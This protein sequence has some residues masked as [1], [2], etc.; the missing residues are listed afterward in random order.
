MG[1]SLRT[2]EGGLVYHALNPGNARLV[3]FDDD[4]D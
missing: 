3:V 1:R 2:A 4:G